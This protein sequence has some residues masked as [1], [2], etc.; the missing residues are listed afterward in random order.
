MKLKPIGN[1]I[2]ARRVD[3]DVVSK[4]GI[5]IP[6]IARDTL[7]LADIVA[8]PEG[9]TDAVVGDRVV[10]AKYAETTLEVEGEKVVLIAAADVLA[11][12]E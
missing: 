11:V 6:T 2:I 10:F 4:G 3:G 12:F 5:Y 9:Y 1:R 7:M 8:V